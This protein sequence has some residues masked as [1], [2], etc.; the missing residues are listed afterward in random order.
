MADEP[1]PAPDTDHDHRPDPAATVPAN[2]PPEDPDDLLTDPS[3]TRRD[4]PVEDPKIEDEDV[5]H[6]RQAGITGPK[7]N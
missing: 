1:Q 6:T 4:R 5:V 7:L 3:A 2:D